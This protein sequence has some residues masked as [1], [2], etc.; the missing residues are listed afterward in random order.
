MFFVLNGANLPLDICSEIAK[1]FDYKLIEDASTPSFPTVLIQVTRFL[2]VLN[3][4]NQL[5]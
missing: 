3:T 2:V 4:L 1:R 5:V